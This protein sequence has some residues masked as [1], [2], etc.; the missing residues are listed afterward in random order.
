MQEKLNT[1]VNFGSKDKPHPYSLQICHH[2]VIILN[3]PIR[4]LSEIING[5]GQTI[6]STLNRIPTSGP[7]VIYTSCHGA[8]IVMANCTIVSPKCTILHATMVSDITMPQTDITIA[9]L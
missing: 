5:G 6:L 7:L 2:Q 4:K 1:P 3:G 8:T 9:A